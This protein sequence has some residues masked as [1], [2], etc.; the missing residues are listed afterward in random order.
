MCNHP[1]LF[2]ARPIVSSFVTETISYHVPSLVFNLSDEIF[3]QQLES[4]LFYQA[5]LADLETNQT[6]YASLRSQNLQTPRKLIEEIMSP[7]TDLNNKP[8][9]TSCQFFPDKSFHGL[10][11]SMAPKLTHLASRQMH[12]KRLAHTKDYIIRTNRHHCNFSKPVYGRDLQDLVGFEEF[13]MK[14]LK[15]TYYSTYSGSSYATCA[16]TVGYKQNQHR[17]ECF[18]KQSKS[19]GEM[20][21]VVKDG[22]YDSKKNYEML[23]VLSRFIVYVPGVVTPLVGSGDLCNGGGSVRLCVPH[24]KPSLIQKWKWV[25]EEIVAKKAG[26]KEVESVSK[27]QL[28]KLVVKNFILFS[29]LFKNT[30][31]F[32]FFLACNLRRRKKDSN[33]IKR[34]IS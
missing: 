9:Q 23:D 8:T 4:L 29:I 16:Q 21:N 14:P 26:I 13:F 27:E 15:T 25:A 22:F 32:E 31:G 6:V 5:S 12:S 7:S 24:P 28:V 17:G 1:D 33:L 10:A 18:W 11:S 3:Q 20:L 2:E 30:F 19:L 34:S